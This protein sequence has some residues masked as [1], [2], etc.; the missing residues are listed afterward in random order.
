MV[1]EN[2]Q[3]WITDTKDIEPV[4]ALGRGRTLDKFRSKKYNPLIL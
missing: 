1:G 4:L 2:R 3:V